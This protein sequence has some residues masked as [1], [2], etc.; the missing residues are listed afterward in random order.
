[1]AF[2]NFPGGRGPGDVEG[3]ADGRD[4]GAGGLHRGDARQEGTMAPERRM[5]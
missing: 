4:G 2:G 1:M 5:W 3:C